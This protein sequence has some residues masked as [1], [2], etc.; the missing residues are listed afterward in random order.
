MNATNENHRGHI[1]QQFNQELEDVKTRMLEMGGMVEKQLKMA[2]QAVLD[3]DSKLGEEVIARD[4]EIDS[5]EVQIDEVCGLILARRQPAAG[6]LRLVLAVIKTIRD[7]ER[8]GDESAKIA[9][10]AV[11]LGE[12]GIPSEGMVEFRHIADLVA[13]M[14][15][16]TLNAFARLDAKS[17]LEIAEQDSQVD[18]E[19]GSAIRSLATYMM[20]DNRTITRVLNVLWALRALERIGDHA[21]NISEQ[22]VYVAKGVDV[23]HENLDDFAEQIR[24]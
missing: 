24:S 5:L 18:S 16:H 12:E 13:K 8:M 23:R 3:A 2:S 11:N 19:Y 14:V 22:I 6:D 17:A 4:D 20:G 21:K 7:L 1:S 10:M 9:H 15:N